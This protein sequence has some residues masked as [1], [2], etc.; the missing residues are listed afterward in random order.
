MKITKRSLS[1][2]L[3]KLSMEMKALKLSVDMLL[4]AHNQPRLC[5]GCSAVIKRP[6][7]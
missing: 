5:D 3:H 2:R 6:S 1:L 7:K 4:D